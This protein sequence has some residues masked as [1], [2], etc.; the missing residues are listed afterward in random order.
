MER[1][2]LHA[3][4]LGFMHPIKKEFVQPTQFD[5]LTWKIL[6]GDKTDNVPPMTGM[7]DKRAE[8]LLLETNIF[9]INKNLYNKDISVSFRKFIRPEKKFKDLEHL[10]KQIKIDIRKAKK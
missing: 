7:T 1:F 10:K 8:K 5:Y 4:E 6:R 2:S 3:K 9:G